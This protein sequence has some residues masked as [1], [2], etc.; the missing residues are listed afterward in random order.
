MEPDEIPAQALWQKTLCT[1]SSPVPEERRSVVDGMEWMR[2]KS[3]GWRVKSKNWWLSQ[4]ERTLNLSNHIHSNQGEQ[5]PPQSAHPPGSV[6][7]LKHRKLS[8]LNGVVVG[9]R[10]IKKKF[11]SVTGKIIEH[12]LF[13][14]PFGAGFHSKSLSARTWRL[15]PSALMRQKN[16]GCLGNHWF[17]RWELLISWAVLLIGH[18]DSWACV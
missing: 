8:Y 2:W 10:W 14:S 18:P 4:A 12:L 11:F 16:V 6:S 9:V 13:F 3:A 1:F 15:R 5:T 17:S 7:R